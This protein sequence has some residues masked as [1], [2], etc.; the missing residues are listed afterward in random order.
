MKIY[1]ADNATF[2]TAV[3]RPEIYAYCA[4]ATFYIQR[5]QINNP[6]YPLFISK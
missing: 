5:Y 2:V 6:A 1:N 4:R 3:S